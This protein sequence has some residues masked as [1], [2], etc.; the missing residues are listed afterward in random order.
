MPLSCIYDPRAIRTKV[1]VF[2]FMQKP[3]CAGVRHAYSNYRCIFA[4]KRLLE[5]SEMLLG[6]GKT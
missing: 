1:Q 3:L 2:N 6:Q 5:T 4:M